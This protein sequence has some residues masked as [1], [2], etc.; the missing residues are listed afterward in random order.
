V[1]AARSGHEAPNAGDRP[2]D[3]RLGDGIAP[4][5]PQC[6]HRGIAWVLPVGRKQGQI[7]HIDNAVVVKV[8]V[9]PHRVA[10]LPM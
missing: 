8:A 10:V 5:E 3:R 2:K 7:I 9:G 4:A 1:G 6:R